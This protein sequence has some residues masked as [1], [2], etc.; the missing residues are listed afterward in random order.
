ARLRAALA[1]HARPLRSPRD[2]FAY[3]IGTHDQH[4]VPVTLGASAIGTSGWRDYAVEAARLE[5]V[6]A[7]ERVKVDGRSTL[8]P[9][10]EGIVSIVEA[11]ASDRRSIHTVSTWDREQQLFY[12]IPCTLG[13]EG[14]VCR[15]CD[16][17]RNEDVRTKLDA[18][19]DK[20]RKLVAASAE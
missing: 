13:R 3:A 11:V 12:S 14:V 19:L 5:T 1:K 20:L 4:F 18:C 2:V 15:H 6:K 9:V 7:A 8:H 17:L 10:V 16:L